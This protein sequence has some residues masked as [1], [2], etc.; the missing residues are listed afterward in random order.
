MTRPGVIQV[1]Q[2]S[3]ACRGTTR[4][5]MRA[6]SRRLVEEFERFVKD[7]SLVRGE[8]MASDPGGA[9]DAKK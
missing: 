3:A 9:S 1:S 4:S 2:L 8:G 7:N 5:A 6:A